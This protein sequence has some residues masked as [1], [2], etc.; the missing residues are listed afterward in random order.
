MRTL[1]TEQQIQTLRCYSRLIIAYSGGL[2]STV[3]LHAVVRE[4]ASTMPL[5]ALHINHQLSPNAAAWEQ[6]CRDFC[7]QLAFHPLLAS[8]ANPRDIA[9]SPVAFHAVK[10]DILRQTDLENAARKARYAVFE[11][12][13]EQGD[14]LLLAHH[15]DD[16]VE[17]FFLQLFRGAG[18]EGLAAMSARRNFGLGHLCRPLLDCSKTQLIDYAQQQ[19]LSYI[20]DESNQD[21]RFARNYIRHQLLPLIEKRW[22]S[23]A[24]NVQR[25]I[26][27]CQQA[28]HNLASLAV[29]DE[30]EPVPSADSMP[31]AVLRPLTYNRRVNV[32]R[33]WLLRYGIQCPSERIFSRIETELL[34]ARMDANPEVCWGDYCLRRYQQTLYLTRAV[35]PS[36]PSRQ[37]WHHFPQDLA[38]EESGLV[39][40]VLNPPVFLQQQDIVIAPRIGGES[41][42]LGGQNRVL[43][44]LLQQWK[45]PPWQRAHIPLVYANGILISVVDYANADELGGECQFIS[46]QPLLA[47]KQNLQA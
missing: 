21:T 2:D 15:R 27:H 1:F 32:L 19:Q 42:R 11:Q 7:Q 47:A 17:T 13:M 12:Y 20:E 46:S 37:V 30:Q 4:F 33:H 36:P 31:L 5:L 23:V 39:I 16:Q 18:I 3:L 44:K 43:K 45:I 28:R 14:A 29:I 41:I 8:S 22:P 40:S 24:K 26:G 34:A 25:T 38:L 6:H 35:L 9:D 10:V